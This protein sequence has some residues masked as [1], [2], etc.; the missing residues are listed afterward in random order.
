M[1]YRVVLHRL[2]LE[3]LVSAYEWVARNAPVTAAQ[4]LDRFQDAL[5][6]L[7]SFPQRQPLA[8]ENRKVDAEAPVA[9]TVTFQLPPELEFAPAQG[10]VTTGHVAK[11]LGVLGPSELCSGAKGMEA[12]LPWIK[13]DRSVDVCLDQYPAMPRAP[14]V[15]ASF[16]VVLVWLFLCL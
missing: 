2:A 13:L 11:G 15:A 7:E 3:D 5:L 9:V 16:I 1:K 10:Q 14:I 4:W 8:R 6:T 12:P